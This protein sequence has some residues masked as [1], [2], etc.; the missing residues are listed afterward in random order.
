MKPKTKIFFFAFPFGD[1]EGVRQELNRRATQGW[2]FEGRFG[3]ITARFQATA[4]QELCYDVVPA[5][6][7]R[8][9]EEL[10]HEIQLR[11]SRGWSPVDTLW[12]MDVYQSLPCQSPEP[13]RTAEDYRG[14]QALFRSWLLWSLA[15]LGVTLVALGLI[16]QAFRLDWAALS[17]QWCLS[18]SRGMLCLAL[19]L[20]AALALLWLGWLSFCLLRRCRPHR[21]CGRGLLLLRGGLQALAVGLLLV[22][23]AV[24]WTDQVPRLWMRLALGAGL[25]LTLLLAPAVSRGDRRRQTLVLGCGVFACLL[26]SMVLGWTVSPLRL[27]TGTQGTSWRQEAERPTLRAEALG[28]EEDSRQVNA[29][30]R[31]SQS[32]LVKEETYYESWPDGTALEVTVYTCTLPGLT[33]PLWDDLVPEAARESPEE[34]RLDS[35][36]WHQLWYRSGRRLIHLSGT[37]DWQT[38]GLGQRALELVLGNG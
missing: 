25:A 28:L 8:G 5:P 18:D 9:P 2:A 29:C 31:C 27:D 23:L 10:A 16:S 22:T 20:G 15:F 7:R 32:L 26:L 13:C 35:E 3:L 33:G 24:L 11:E 38:D 21:P 6:P 37:P 4:R 14:W 1:Y 36:S 17:H 30:Y 34:A 12:G 19:P